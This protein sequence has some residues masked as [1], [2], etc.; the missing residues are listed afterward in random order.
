VIGLEGAILKND[1]DDWGGWR[2]E[3]IPAGAPAEMLTAVD[4][5]EAEAD[6]DTDPE[7][8]EDADPEPEEDA[9]PEDAD[10]DD[11]DPEL[12]EALEDPAGGFARPIW[13]VGVGRKLAAIVEGRVE[14]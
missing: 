7:P 12:E 3:R 6:P 9:D 11:A 10:P 8:E 5:G 1:V 13:G 2:K 14:K 4:E